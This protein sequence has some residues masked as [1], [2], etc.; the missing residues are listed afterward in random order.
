LQKRKGEY[1]SIFSDLFYILKNMGVNNN[2]SSL[3]FLGLP[4]RWEGEGV[5]LKI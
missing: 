5:R 2:V 4:R 3:L 1:W